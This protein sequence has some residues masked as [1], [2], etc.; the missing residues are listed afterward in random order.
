[1]TFAWLSAIFMLVVDLVALRW[2]AMAQALTAKTHNHSVVA[3]IFQVLLLPW[4]VF[5]LG[6]GVTLL[7][8]SLTSPNG[9]AN[10]AA[11]HPGWLFGLGLVADLFFGLRARRL[12]LGGM[13]PLAAQR[14]AATSMPAEVEVTPPPPKNH[15]RKHL[16]RF[17]A[18]LVL[19]LAGGWYFWPQSPVRQYPP[20]VVVSASL[21]QGPLRVFPS[22]S[23]ALIILPDGS[24]W[25]CGQAGNILP[26]TES[27]TQLGTNYD[28]LQAA[29]ASGLVAVRKDGTLW[30]QTQRDVATRGQLDPVDAGHDWV[31]VATAGMHSCVLKRDGTLWA[32]GNNQLGQ[33][34][35][36]PGPNQT[37]LVQVG[38]NHDWAA[39]C[40]NG[41]LA[42]LALR[43]DGTLWAWGPAFYSGSANFNLNRIALPTQVCRETNWVGF[44]VGDRGVQVRNR[45][46]EL[47]EPFY[48]APNGDLGASATCLLAISN[49]VPDH[50]AFADCGRPKVFE[51]HQD[52]TLWEADYTI[53]A[54]VARPSTKSRQVGNRSDWLSLWGGGGTA[55]G[56]T[57]NGTLW[58]WGAD[59]THAP[60]YD[61]NARLKLLRLRIMGGFSGTSSRARMAA[62]NGPSQQ[63]QK[64]PRP[65]MELSPAAQNASTK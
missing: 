14:F 12:L 40:C 6:T 43:T 62:A 20:P 28:W 17:A 55:F 18:A 56:L 50:V 46:G 23:G 61:F 52:G 13:R 25:R 8:L 39:I 51:I 58:T 47:W 53:G 64:D 31:Q 49:V 22:N 24:L 38:T 54:T 7:W 34:G 11:I 2:V 19:L 41:F 32:W 37:N 65:L 15:R 42:T 30:E 57:A 16:L 35:N 10:D 5:G 60:A 29:S 63:Y 26:R 27:P 48:A 59:L 9:F 21:G 36:G 4:I 33:L 1:M 44:A 3:T 45:K